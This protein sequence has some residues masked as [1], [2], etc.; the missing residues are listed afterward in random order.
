MSPKKEI[1][2]AIGSKENMAEDIQAL[3]RQMVD[4]PLVTVVAAKEAKNAV[5]EKA[6]ALFIEGNSV[7]VLVD[8]DRGLVHDMRRQ[9]HLLRERIQVILYL[10]SP[11]SDDH[12]LIEGRTVVMEQKKERRIEERV[13]NFIRKYEKKM[14]HEAFRL[15]LDRIRDESVLESE[16]IKLVN[17][18]GDR[19]D[20]R[21]KDILAVVAE[22]HEESLISLFEALARKDKGEAIAIFE[23]LLLNGFNILAIHSFLVKQ[24]RLLLQAKDMEEIFRASPEFAIFAKT[25]GKWKEGMDLKPLDKRQYLPFQKPYYAFN[26]SKTSQGMSRKDLMSFFDMLAEFDVRIKSG[27]KHD[28]ALLECGLIG[29]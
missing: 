13:R 6:S 19:R 2:I 24:I 12:R 11:P 28:R 8:P 16:L 3:S 26:L 17:Y 25:F 22:T 9:L 23:N 27:T 29:T 4:D 10:S 15:L 5:I 20:I 14:T 18:V 7:L 1:I 21:S